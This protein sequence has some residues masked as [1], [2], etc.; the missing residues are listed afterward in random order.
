MIEVQSELLEE[1]A[2]RRGLSPKRVLYEAVQ[3]YT[4]AYMQERAEIL[5]GRAK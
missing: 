4:W 3:A 1:I 5:K 2:K